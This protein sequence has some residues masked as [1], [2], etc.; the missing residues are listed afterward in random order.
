M[1]RSS[2][3]GT[4]LSHC[5]VVAVQTSGQVG[6]PPARGSQ[7]RAP[8]VHAQPRGWVHVKQLARREL[9]HRGIH[10]SEPSYLV[11]PPWPL[12]LLV[13]NFSPARRP[14]NSRGLGVVAVSSA[15]FA[16]HARVRY[17]QEKGR[18]WGGPAVR[19]QVRLSHVW[20]PTRMKDAWVKPLH[21]GAR[22]TRCVLARTV[23]V[24][25]RMQDTHTRTHA[26]SHTRAH[27]HPHPPP[28]RRAGATPIA[29]YRS[30]DGTTMKRVV[31]TGLLMGDVP[32]KLDDDSTMF[33]KMTVD[34]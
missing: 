15:S 12:P 9:L 16:K 25:G 17:L 23:Q 5:G 28:R 2:T 6:P 4:L 21:R 13:I 3:T 19:K 11:A 32:E 30:V 31:H 33:R 10:A 18:G 20:V 27:A 22:M 8:R 29:Y 1:R 34:S 26:H 7:A 24:R 14:L